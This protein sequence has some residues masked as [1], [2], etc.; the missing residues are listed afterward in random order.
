MSDT[1]ESVRYLITT[2]DKMCENIDAHFFT[3]HYDTFSEMFKSL[4]RYADLLE[5]HEALMARV[6]CIV[7]QRGRD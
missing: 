2:L 5:Q 6:D 3:T 7:I 4:Q 1:P